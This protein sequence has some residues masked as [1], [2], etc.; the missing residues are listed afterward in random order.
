MHTTMYKT[1][2]FPGQHQQKRIHL[3]MQEMR[4]MWAQSLEMWAQSLGQKDS[5][6]QEMA[7]H[8]SNFAWEIPWAEEPGGL[9]SIGSQRVR[10][11]KHAP[12]NTLTPLWGLF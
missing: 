11:S 9:Q 2:G 5:L 1:E 12:Q 4:E 8:C 6:E 7:T 10:L 3:P